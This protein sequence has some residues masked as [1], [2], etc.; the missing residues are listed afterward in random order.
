MKFNSTTITTAMLALV[1]I[2]F[3]LPFAEI[4]C[5]N[6]P[7]Y[8]LN[9]KD[10]LRGKPVTKDLF[11]DYAKRSG[12][13]EEFKKAEAD[14]DSLFKLDDLNNTIPSNPWAIAAFVMAA[15]G[16]L[17]GVVLRRF[18]T[19]LHL[20]TSVAT[21]IALIGLQISMSGEYAKSN[22]FIKMI[23]EIKFLAGYWMSLII[24]GLVAGISIIAF[25]VER[26]KEAQE[27][28]ISSGSTIQKSPPI[29]TPVE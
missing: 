25:I 27:I 21:V 10:L 5:N 19:V 1:L 12:Q 3:F 28:N 29:D 23:V 11:Y 8:T 26:K 7:F 24:S 16:V 22:S 13:E 17:T 9:G 6:V 20:V 14:P 4:S 18:G 15:I 2:C